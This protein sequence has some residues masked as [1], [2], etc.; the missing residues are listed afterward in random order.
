MDCVGIFSQFFAVLVVPAIICGGF[1]TFLQRL[2]A[3][4]NAVFVR[5]H[6]L[7]RTAWQSTLIYSFS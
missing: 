1:V 6:G 7:A 2:V 3:V 4:V 5:T